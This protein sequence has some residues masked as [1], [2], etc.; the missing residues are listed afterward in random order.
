MNVWLHTHLPRLQSGETPDVISV[1]VPGQHVTYASWVSIKNVEFK[2]HERGR[3]R[4]VI[5]GVRNVHAWVIGEEILRVGSDWSYAQASRP[6]GYRQA[7]YDPWK[8]GT[9]VDSETLEPV[10][11]ADLVIMSGKNVFYAV[12]PALREFVQSGY[13]SRG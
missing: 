1:K 6:A 5:E 12:T 4:C 10:L 2:V 9:F 3:Q 11:R 7:V 13:G 8:G